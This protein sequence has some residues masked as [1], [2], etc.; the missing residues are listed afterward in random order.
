M[1]SYRPI[2][3]LIDRVR[4]RWRTQQAFEAIARASLAAIV[5]VAVALIAALS[6][7]GKPGVLAVIGIGAVVLTLAAI[8]WGLLPLRRIPG[9]RQVA[10]FIEE[11]APELDDRLVSAVDIATGERTTALAGRMLADAT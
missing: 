2:R 8:L 1:D 11:R 7:S 9:D 3:E 6:T 5:V 4:R 10:R